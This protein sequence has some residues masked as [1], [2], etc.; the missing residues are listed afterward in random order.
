MAEVIVSNLNQLLAE[1]AACR[2]C[3]GQI[4]DPRPVLRAAS[5]A[6]LLIVGQ[7]PGTKVHASGIPW[8]DASGIRLR[9][10]MGLSD[11]EFYDPSRVAIVPM[12]F[13]YPGKGKS[14]DLPPA[15]ECAPTWHP[16][17]FQH[18]PNIEC[19]L[20]IG[21]YA[22]RH[23]LSDAPTRLTDTVKNWRSYAPSQ[24]VLPHPSP[25]NQLWLRRNPWFERDVV[26]ALQDRVQALIRG[27]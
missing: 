4:P 27:V 12:G 23:Y 8:D 9:T 11:A 1:I 22:Q 17:V 14:G 20:L 7:A 24:F 25:R 16:Q 3:E 2:I 5:S 21:L 10:W 6:R 13:C 19:T 15:P 26:P 18:L